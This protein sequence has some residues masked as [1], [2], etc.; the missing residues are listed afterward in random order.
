[1]TLH[2]GMP[3]GAASITTQAAPSLVFIGLDLSLTDT[4]V[5]VISD[6]G[7]K[8]YS[9]TSAGH[10]GDT[11]AIMAAR[12]EKIASDV[13]SHI[14]DAANVLVAIEGPAFMSKF[15]SPH[16]RAG[17]WWSIV[18]PLVLRGQNVTVIPPNNL[19][20]YATGKGGAKKDVVLAAV[21]RRY[22]D[23]AVVNNNI[24]DS[25][26]LA[27]MLARHWGQPIEESMPLAHLAAMDK[28]RWT[29]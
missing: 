8:F 12:L 2:L 25:L 11:T 24:A 21:V 16:E 13:L 14:P 22:I 19:K 20:M 18:I 10:K 26:V 4:G 17:L 27:A 5:T 23:V 3:E 6:E 1:M 28:V 29:A 9:I 15:G 7:V